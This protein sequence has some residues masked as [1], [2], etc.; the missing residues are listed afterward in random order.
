MKKRTGFSALAGLCV[1][2]L[3]SMA[4]AA[5]LNS[6]AQSVSLTA[7]ANESLTVT[8]TG[9]N[10][11]NWAAIDPGSDSTDANNQSGSV[12]VKVD[13]RLAN[14][15]T[16]V[17]VYGYFTSAS[18]AMAGPTANIPS[19]AVMIKGGDL[20][21]YTAV[22]GNPPATN[23]SGPAAVAGA[24]LLMRTVNITS[25]NRNSSDTSTYNFALDLT[26][27]TLPQLPSETFTGT[28]YIEAQTTP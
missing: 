9:S 23:L 1:L 27:G 2:G 20:G 24:T 21:A 6:G 26:G 22:S 15:R 12:P 14:S 18:A 17:K 16:A 8:L 5:V 25:S 19:S 4:S 13:W 28:L 3:A 10:A 11:V 7:T